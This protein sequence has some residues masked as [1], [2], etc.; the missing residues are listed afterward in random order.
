M[1]CKIGR[2]SRTIWY[3]IVQL[4]D[5]TIVKKMSGSCCFCPINRIDWNKRGGII[6]CN[7]P[8]GGQSNTSSLAGWYVDE[9][10]NY[11]VIVPDQTALLPGW[12]L[13][14]PFLWL[15]FMIFVPICNASAFVFFEQNGRVAMEH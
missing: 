8:C 1:H 10:R 9:R 6:C 2:G 4:Y 3:D 13:L 15:N 5:R 12:L 7:L 14:L 11:Q